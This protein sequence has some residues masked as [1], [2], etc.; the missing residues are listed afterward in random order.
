MITRYTRCMISSASSIEYL[1]FLHLELLLFCMDRHEHRQK[2]RGLM[3][4]DLRLIA[5]CQFPHRLALYRRRLDVGNQFNQCLS[6]RSCHHR[7]HEH[8][9]VH[10][11]MDRASV[12]KRFQMVISRR[13]SNVMNTASFSAFL[14]IFSKLLPPVL[15]SQGYREL[16]QSP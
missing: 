3:G 2:L 16:F 5:L 11:R 14:Q 12:I 1:L 10:G 9:A 7:A 8:L 15:A 4:V 6:L 13:P